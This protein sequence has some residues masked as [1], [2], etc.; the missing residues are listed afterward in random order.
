MGSKSRV[1][2]GRR[3]ERNRTPVVVGR[4]SGRQYCHRSQRRW[5]RSQSRAHFGKSERKRLAGCRQHARL[6]HLATDFCARIFNCRN[7]HRRVRAGV[8][9]DVVKRNIGAMGGVVDIRSARGFGTTISISL[10]LTLAIL[11]GMSIKVGEEIY[12]L[13]L[14]Y[15]IESLQ[16]DPIDVKE[17]SGQGRVVKVR[18]GISAA[19]TA[20]PGV[21]HR[22]DVH[23][24]V[25]RDR[26]DPRIRWP[27]GGLVCRRFGR[28]TAGSGEK[29]GIEL[30]QG[31]GN[32]RGD[33]SRRWR[34]FADYRC[35][36]VTA[37]EPPIERRSHFFPIR[38]DHV[39]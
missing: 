39:T 12:I 3:Q 32:I 19:D 5:R 21:W 36:R 38:I 33:D 25:R 6:R 24:S 20:I 4:A 31:G 18:R 35:R 34:G 2:N 1:S 14:G 13:P 37:I 11:D 27:Q 15:V 10:P 29:S 17:I 8:G 28:P 30:P 23:R 26:R 16:P 7:R 22:P 9:M